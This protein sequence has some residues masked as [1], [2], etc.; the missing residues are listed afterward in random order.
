[1][2][3]ASLFFKDVSQ[4]ARLIYEQNGVFHK[5]LVYITCSVVAKYTVYF[6]S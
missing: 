2:A 3:G 5:N 1:M 4:Q 6:L